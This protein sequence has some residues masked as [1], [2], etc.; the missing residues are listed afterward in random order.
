MSTTRE[1][2]EDDGSPGRSVSYVLRH[3]PGG[4][5]GLMLLAAVAL[6]GSLAVKWDWLVAA[7]IAPLLLSAMP[8][9][10][11]CALGFCMNR[12][13]GRACASEKVE[14]GISDPEQPRTDMDPVSNP[15]NVRIKE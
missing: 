4:R 1:L 6:I 10:A 5:R 8:C 2:N 11:M 3:Y 15:N 12:K 9:L 13:T 14:S 7:G